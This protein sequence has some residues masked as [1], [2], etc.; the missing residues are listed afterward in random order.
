[1]ASPVVASP[2]PATDDFLAPYEDG[3]RS[4]REVEINERLV[5]YYHMRTLGEAHVEKDF[6]VYQFDRRTGELLDKKTHWRDDLPGSLPEY[7]IS[8][9]EALATVEGDPHWAQ[10]CIIS[11]ESDVYPID[12]TPEN[13][14]WV[15]RSKVEG[16]LIVS[17]ID[18]VDGSLLGYGLPPPYTAFSM[19]GPTGTVPVCGGGWDD[20]YE[21]AYAWFD[22]MGYITE[23][24]YQPRLDKVQSHVQSVTTSLFYEIAHGGSYEFTIGCSDAGMPI[25]LTSGGLGM[26]I[27]DSPKMPFA[28]IASCGGLCETGEGTFSY[29][30]RKGSVESTATVGYCH[31]DAIEC[32][33]CW[34]QA[35]GW[36]TTL[37]R[38][39]KSGGSVAFAFDRASAAYPMCAEP[40]C[41]RFAGDPDFA[42]VPLVSRT[43]HQFFVDPWGT[44]D[45]PTI[46]AA[47]DAA[48]DGDYIWLADGTFAGIGNASILLDGKAVVIRS[49]SGDPDQCV[50]DCGG[51]GRA[52]CIDSSP[53]HTTTFVG[54]AMINGDA[55]AEADPRGGAI[56]CLGSRLSLA[57]C[58]IQNSVAGGDGGAICCDSASVALDYCLITDNETPGSGGGLFC[59][60]TTLH[61]IDCILASNVSTG[62]GGGLF[63]E[64]STLDLSGGIIRDN[65]SGGS[66][67]GVHL[68]AGVVGV[69]SSC[70][71]CG[72]EALGDG[73]G[74]LCESP[75]VLERCGIHGNRSASLG[76][77][78]CLPSEFM[79]AGQMSR[80]TLAGNAA[81][82]DGG[83]VWI[84]GAG[85]TVAEYMLIWGNSAGDEGDEVFTGPGAPTLQ[86]NFSNV[87]SSGIAGSGTIEWQWY[88]SHVPP[89]FCDPRD[90]AEAPT[91][92]GD[93][94]LKDASPCA[95]PNS[96]VG[97]VGAL[98]VGCTSQIFRVSSDGTGDFSTIQDAVD[99]IPYYD[100]IELENG[101]YTGVGNRGIDFA[102]KTLT[103]RS[104]SSHADSCI[105]DCEGLA[106]AVTLASGEGEGT[107]LQDLTITGGHATSGGAIY[108]DGS[109]PTVTGC[110]LHHNSADQSGAAV[111]SS[112]GSPEILACTLVENWASDGAAIHS[113]DSEVAVAHTIVAFGVDAQAIS[114]T[115]SGTAS[116]SCCDLYANDGGDWVGCVEGQ[117]GIDGNFSTDP[118]FW[119]PSS[120]DYCLSPFSPCLDAPDCGRVGALG[121]KFLGNRVWHVPGDAPS[122]QAGIDSA[123]AGD[124]VRVAPGTYY[125]YEILMRS[126]V[127]LC[128]EPG[129]ADAVVI[130]AQGHGR[131][132]T[133]IDADSTTS[134]EGITFTGGHA[135]GIWPANAGGGIYCEY[136]SPKITDCVLHSNTAT[137]GGGL[138]CHYSSPTI[139]NC[140]LVGNSGLGD[141]G[142][143]YA[144]RPSTVQVRNCVI[145][146]STQGEGAFSRYGAILVLWCTDIYGNDSGDW[147]T[148]IAEQAG[149]NGNLCEDPCFC[150][151]QDGDYHIRDDSPCAPGSSPPGCDLIGALDVAC[152]STSVA[153]GTGLPSSF[154]L[155]PPVPNPFNP[156]TEIEYGIPAG[157][158]AGRVRVN[159][160]DCLGRRVTT[161]VDGMR[162]PGVYRITWTGADHHN[163]PVASGIYFYRITWNGKSET[164]RM[165]LLK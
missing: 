36:Q 65:S 147:T 42:V 162:A 129:T 96:P 160:Y 64:T 74:A 97:L 38:N 16:E 132:L 17:V 88:I 164:R 69:I 18:A 1:M 70:E 102:G 50:I 72:N 49:V 136:A 119:D 133:C 105:I 87:D 80:C 149:I 22:S 39:M 148:C 143:I 48:V 29:E 90:G 76:G 79:P 56:L 45:V 26:M 40:E 150:D 89:G 135:D 120:H 47:V 111:Y 103:L 4:F 144:Y 21:N 130:D 78:L 161:L 75:V 83:G 20:F 99:A 84:D 7:S 59:E 57:D 100:I 114:C 156:V 146:F 63:V 81:A 104:R 55:T 106:R 118:M 159:V 134:I 37:F 66:G 14:C 138:T 25:S 112:Q 95:P 5:V 67:G 60:A 107:V 10:L 154:Y 158:R 121:R 71:I 141:A 155:G 3:T 32:S 23:A 124:T 153:G 82:L 13:P 33:A 51:A 126:G 12:P 44:G 2:S 137:Y 140:T 117:E 53:L 27:A 113:A 101:T 157:A 165:V 85:S 98:S 122:I 145:A 19:T 8:R 58:R 142:G 91:S 11:P 109:S 73:G 77:G 24:V 94:H 31:M 92:S 43:G 127:C 46:Q 115:G 128:G 6:I 52:F 54:F 152:S 139:M 62:E 35:L 110:V 34:E 41:M 86:F 125:E 131:V 68:S 123:W 151:L 30:F 61:L 93:Y 163:V 9:E 116:L 15:V 108:C 28:F